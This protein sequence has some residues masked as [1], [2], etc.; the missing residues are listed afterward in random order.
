M[1]AD[2]PP[3]APT[4]DP[5]G[6]WSLGI[7]ACPIGT[8]PDSSA[9]LINIADAHSLAGILP[10]FSAP[11]SFSPSSAARS[12]HKDS[13]SNTKKQDE[14][15]RMY[16]VPGHNYKSQGQ[17]V[18][19]MS[20]LSPDERTYRS[21]IITEKTSPDLDKVVGNLLFHLPYMP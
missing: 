10:V 1:T 18:E 16:M 8:K 12:R 2:G 6:T 14:I 4:H 20:N 11:I 21:V 3:Q 17:V 9:M 19:A 13:K 15:Q 7:F 5:A